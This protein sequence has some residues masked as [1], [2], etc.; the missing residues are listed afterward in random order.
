MK[1]LSRSDLIAHAEAWIRDWNAHDV[2]AVIAPWAEDGVFISP[3]AATVTGHPVIQGRAALKTYWQGALKRAGSLHFTP[4]FL[5]V[6][7]ETQSLL[8]HYCSR[9]S[10][11]QV[12][13][14]ELMVFENGKQV[15]GEAF[16]GAEMP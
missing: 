4:L 2:D 5:Q 16:Y 11:R 15:R 1:T 6:D 13:A 9:T 12:R 10:A 3:I 8:V 14:A 7:P